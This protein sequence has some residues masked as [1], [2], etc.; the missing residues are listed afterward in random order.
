[1]QEDPHITAPRIFKQVPRL[2][3]GAGVA[4]CLEDLLPVNSDRR[5]FVVD[6]AHREADITDLLPLRSGDVVEWF[7][8][9]DHEP[10]TVQVAEIRDRVASGG[11][12]GEG[13]MRSRAE[14]AEHPGT[15]PAG[16]SAATPKPEPSTR[17]SWRPG[18][19]HAPCGGMSGGSVAGARSACA[20]R[21]AG[22]V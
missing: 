11:A 17:V 18:G 6:S 19:A 16:F 8:A 4:S 3:Y 9:D 7:P 1:M 14:T 20:P 12:L 22:H 2:L 21:Q 15:A 5:I 10:S 13:E